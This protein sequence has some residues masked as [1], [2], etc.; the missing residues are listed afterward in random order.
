MS[1]ATGAAAPTLTELAE[2]AGL[3]LEEMDGHQR[4]AGSADIYARISHFQ[5][6]DQARAA[7]L[8]P[9]FQAV[10]VNEGAEAVVDGRRVLMLGSN[11]YLG[12]TRHP[13]VIAAAS[14]ALDRWGPSMTGS[15]LLNGTCPV[16]LELERELA[17]FLGAETAIV[18]STGYLANLGTISALVDRRGVAVLDRDVHASIYDAAGLA[19]GRSVRFRHND[20]DHLDAVLSKLGPD[21]PRLVIID[22]AYSMGGDIAPLPQLREV[23]RRR[24]TRMLVDDAHAIGTLGPTGRGT[25]SHW[26]LDTGEDLVIGTFSKTL[27]SVGGFCAGP[28]P[29]TEYIRHFSRPMLF[30]AAPPPPSAA[31]AL[32]ALR[33]IDEEPWRVQRVQEIGARM[34][35]QLAQLGFDV[36]DSGTPII[37]IRVGDEVLTA[38]LWRDL[39]DNGIYTNAVIAPAV[40][41]GQAILRTS[42]IATHTD[43]QLDRAIEVF[44]ECGRRQGVIS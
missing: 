1:E 19:L 16:H 27:A 26:G 17:A 36:G 30:T 14:E 25:A 31:A 8:Y 20:P 24:G 6:A 7:G 32:A 15:R 29:V 18:F 9:F 11:N 37:P 4:E 21:E 2:A 42:Y 5:L 33:L 13:K 43:E 10:E 22:G 39:L 41:R 35:R 44:A 38:T 23:C 40:P 28:E 12:L 3:K 34:K